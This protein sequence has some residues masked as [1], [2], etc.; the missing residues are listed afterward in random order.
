[1]VVQIGI[2]ATRAD[3]KPPFTVAGLASHAPPSLEGSFSAGARANYSPLHLAAS[4]DTL[5]GL[6]CDQKKFVGA[7]ACTRL[8]IHK[9]SKAV[10]LLGS[11]LKS[12]VGSLFP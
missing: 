12:Y 1:M 2:S 8:A 11:S 9:L 10:V 3:E 6:K 4:L 5:R 7:R